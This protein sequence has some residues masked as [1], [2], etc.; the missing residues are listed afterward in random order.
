MEEHQ[1][2]VIMEQADLNVKI[3]KL[4]AFLKSEQSTKL[5][6]VECERLSR[7]LRIMR[8]YS[9]VLGERIAAFMREGTTG[10]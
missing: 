10:A 5:P 7:Q 3:V 2:R 4:A 9:A 6:V 1:E 8:E